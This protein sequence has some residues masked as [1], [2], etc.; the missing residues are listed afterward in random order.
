MSLPPPAVQSAELW[1]DLRGTAVHPRVAV[2]YIVDEL[3][4]EG[5]L[6]PSAGRERLFTKILMSDVSFQKLLN[7]SDPFV[8]ASEILYQ[9]DG[10]SNGFLAL[11]KNSLSLPFGNVM[12]MPKDNVVAVGDPME[13]MRILGDGRWILLENEERELD[14]DKLPMRMDAISSFLDIASTAS[15]GQ[16]GIPLTQEKGKSSLL[17]KTERDA[18]GADD[19]GG[20]AV[21]CPNKSF[22]VQLAS[23]FQCFQTVSTTSMT[24][25]G[26]IIQGG[27]EVYVPSLP[28]AVVLPFDLLL[29]KTAMFVYGQEQF[30]AFE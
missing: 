25:S 5:L 3:E 28:T 1:L 13:A 14:P 7:A 19:R 9:P 27:P 22:L 23:V 20:V 16:W 29:W 30:L 24:E 11:S 26:I 18:K 21:L 4:E 8:E 17:F 15:T 6:L 2:N 12:T 10:T